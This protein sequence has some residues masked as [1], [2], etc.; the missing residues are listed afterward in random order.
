MLRRVTVRT[1]LSEKCIASIISVTRIGE[2]GMLA[3][4]VPSW[5]ILVTL[6]MEAI[7]SSETSVHTRA[8]RR[9]VTEDDILHNHRREN[10]KSYKKFNELNFKQK[11]YSALNVTIQR[12]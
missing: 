12:T 7:R 1:D 3:N 5:P 8:T 4:V 11:L 2:L 9:N 6:M 10:L